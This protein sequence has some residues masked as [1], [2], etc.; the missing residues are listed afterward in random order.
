ML[1]SLG[2]RLQRL[3]STDWVR[4][5][6]G[7]SRRLFARLDEIRVGDT[8][9]PVPKTPAVDLYEREELPET[10][11]STSGIPDYR[12]ATLPDDLSGIDLGTVPPA[13]LLDAV[14]EV[15]KTE[16]PV[17]VDELAR[18]I[19]DASGVKRLT[20]RPLAVIERTCDEAVAQG[21]VRQ[22]GDFFWDLARPEPVIRDRSG[23]PSSSRKIELIAPEELILAAEKVVADSLGMDRNA[24]PFAVCRMLGFNRMSDEMRTRLESTIQR[25]IDDGRLVP[26]GESLIVTSLRNE[27]A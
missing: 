5:P 2:W 24:I 16:G 13:R 9:A 11:E 8:P 27:S 3:W 10:G 1:E 15:V 18:R 4:D 20:S 14:V 7:A 19:A 22:V 12:L 21:K 6:I 17:H 25:L 26:Q 23:L